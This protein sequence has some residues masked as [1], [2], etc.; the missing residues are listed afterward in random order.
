MRIAID[1]SSAVKATRTGVGR[2]I[3]QLVQTLSQMDTGCEFDLLYRPSR[4][5]RRR[6]FIR[7]PGPSF[8]TRCL[9]ERLHFGYPGRISAFHGPDARLPRF[10][11]V[12]LVASVHDTFNA[13][14]ESFANSDFRAKKT[15]RYLDLARRADV[16]ITCSEYTKG[17]FLNHTGADPSKVTVIPHGVDS[18]FG[19]I[20]PPGSRPGT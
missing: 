7:V 10:R 2:Y 6:H 19:S 5:K 11:K 17:R 9:L 4:W 13:D 16:V 20:P 1:V 8:R 15:R 18:K 12:P 14:S 3:T